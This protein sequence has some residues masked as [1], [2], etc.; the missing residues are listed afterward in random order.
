MRVVIQ[1]VERASVRVDA[2]VIGAIEAGLVIFVGVGQ[3]TKHAG[4]HSI[5]RN[6]LSNTPTYSMYNVCIS[7]TWAPY[8]LVVPNGSAD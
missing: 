6:L 5:A 4:V 8:F 3:Y 2:E 1:R 7:N